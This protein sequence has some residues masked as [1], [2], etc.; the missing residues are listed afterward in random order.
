MCKRSHWFMDLWQL[1][2]WSTTEWPIRHPI[3]EALF[4]VSVWDHQSWL[5]EVQMTQPHTC[6]SQHSTLRISS[7]SHNINTY[8]LSH[9][10]HSNTPSH[11]SAYDNLRVS[12][13]TLLNKITLRG[14]TAATLYAW[15]FG[16]AT[17]TLYCVITTLSWHPK[18][19]SLPREHV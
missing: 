8:T 5:D 18:K 17:L 12:S 2:A 3:S 10:T 11:I 13:W 9:I 14:N 4:L 6:N 7:L 16:W 15:V 1:V 19:A